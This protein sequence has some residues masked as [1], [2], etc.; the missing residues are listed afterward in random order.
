MPYQ[1]DRDLPKGVRDNLPA[2]ARDTWRRVF[3][4]VEKEE[5]DA[6]QGDDCMRKAEDAARQAAW[7][8]VKRQGYS[9]GE[10]GMWQKTKDRS[11]DLSMAKER[12]SR[13]GISFKVGKGHLTPPAGF[14]ADPAQY[15][16]PVNFKYPLTPEGRVAAA[17]SYFNQDGQ[18]EAGGYTSGEWATIGQRIARKAGKV[19]RDG[20]VVDKQAS[21]KATRQ[22]PDPWEEVSDT[23]HVSSAVFR[24][25]TNGR[26]ASAVV[27]VR[28]QKTGR[29]RW[30]TVSSGTF[31]D[32]LEEIVALHA[33]QY[34]LTWAEKTGMYGPLRLAHIPNPVAR[35]ASLREQWKSVVGD[36]VMVFDKGFLPMAD[37][38]F[39]KA[40]RMFASPNEHRLRNLIEMVGK[41]LSYLVASGQIDADIG[42]CDYQTL[43]GGSN[44]DYPGCFL[45]ESGLYDENALAYR[46]RR[47]FDTHPGEVSIGF[48]YDRMRLVVGKDSVVYPSYNN[49]MWRFERSLLPMGKA[50]FPASYLDGATGIATL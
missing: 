37:L 18:R 14:P 25:L 7:S 23:F 26:T 8:S 29:P 35:D 45:V 36:Y 28:C 12:A 41:D 50:A 44:A 5:L 9:K 22:A 31:P 1:R 3:N 47:Y 20:K 46:A 27:N 11:E 33:Q 4:A 17:V 39:S 43:Q 24:S 30:I 2:D 40:L 21:V 10:D 38:A 34:A 6:C 42:E 13:Y 48:L 19:Y 16:D 32:R 49:R 15:G